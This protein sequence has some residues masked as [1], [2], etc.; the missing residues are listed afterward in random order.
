MK[1]MNVWSNELEWKPVEVFS[2]VVMRVPFFRL[3]H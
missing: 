2:C 1:F 3:F